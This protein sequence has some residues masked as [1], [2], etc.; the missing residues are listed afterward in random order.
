MPQTHGTPSKASCAESIAQSLRASTM[1]GANLSDIMFPLFTDDAREL[2][3]DGYI[4]DMVEA[5]FWLLFC[6]GLHRACGGKFH[7]AKFHA[8]L[9]N[10]AR[11]R[12]G[13]N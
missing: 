10:V 3:E 6:G 8:M 1:V 5:P 9:V 13:A 11:A 2:I 12:R 4:D 7:D